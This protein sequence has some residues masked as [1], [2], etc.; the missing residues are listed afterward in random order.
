MGSEM[1]CSNGG[2]GG[3]RALLF[4]VPPPINRYRNG[5]Y[6]ECCKNYI[7]PDVGGYVSVCEKSHIGVYYHE[8]CCEN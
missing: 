8:N 2:R 1:E 4:C 6:V 3:W 5:E 7:E